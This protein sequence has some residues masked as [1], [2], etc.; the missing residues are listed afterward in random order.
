M[1]GNTGGMST[2]GSEPREVPRALP[3]GEQT[4]ES[5]SQRAEE[6]AAGE[7]DAAELR[8]QLDE[9][10]DRYLRLAADFD[11]F[12]RR[13]VQ[14]RADS[15]RYSS[16]EAA[17]TLLPVL[18]NLRR[19]VE[20]A[21]EGGAEDFFVNGLHLVVREFES[22]LE[23]LGIHPVPAVGEPFDPSV[24]EAVSGEESD[25]VDRDT[26][27]AEIQPGYRLHDRLIRPALVRVAHPRNPY[28]AA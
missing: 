3:A 17:R 9:L 22:A 23:R 5:P 1:A 21:P 24:H 16:E 4:E 25:E 7:L 20:H 12:K 8:R 2:N 11:N 13:R 27:V 18:D 6:D 10:Q 14:E 19:A 26:V 15:L 28:T